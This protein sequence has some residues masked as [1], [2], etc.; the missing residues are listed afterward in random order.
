[1]IELNYNKY[2]N[3]EKYQTLFFPK[4]YPKL[5]NHSIICNTFVNWNV[6]RS[7]VFVVV[8]KCEQLGNLHYQRF[9]GDYNAVTHTNIHL[10]IFILLTCSK[11]NNIFLRSFTFIKLN[12][13]LIISVCV[14]VC[15]LRQFKIKKV[16]PPLPLI[17]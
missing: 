14:F 17:I 13:I 9:M 12:I 7:Y 11:F 10:L 3:I 1:M 8:W 5:F 15:S 16:S 2:Y 4:L 6:G